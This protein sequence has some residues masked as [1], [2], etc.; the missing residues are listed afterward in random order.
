MFQV[1][2]DSSYTP[3][4]PCWFLIVASVTLGASDSC[5]RTKLVLWQRGTRHLE[6]FSAIISFEHSL[7]SS[8]IPVPSF[9]YK[10]EMKWYKQERFPKYPLFL[11]LGFFS[12]LPFTLGEIKHT[13][14]EA[15]HHQ[16]QRNSGDQEN[17]LCTGKHSDTPGAQGSAGC[18]QVWV[19][20]L[21]M[22]STICLKWIFPNLYCSFFWMKVVLSVC[23]IGFVSPGPLII[24]TH[25]G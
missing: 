16:R 15:E 4:M 20:C 17:Q 23:N 9:L 6:D 22:P 18:L 2:T 13:T 24:F 7:P 11:S 1:R 14:V 3:Q 8:P 19:I 10:K 25:K 12:P 5:I 21:F